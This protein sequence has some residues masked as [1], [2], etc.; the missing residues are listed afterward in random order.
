M[1]AR[2]VKSEMPNK[3]LPEP[4]STW[5]PEDI[6]GWRREQFSVLGF[7]GELLSFLAESRID[8]HSVTGW[9]VKGADPLTAVRL[10]AGLDY[11][12]ED[13]RFDHTKFDKLVLDANP[14]EVPDLPEEWFEADDEPPRRTV[15]G[16]L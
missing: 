1:P 6:A 12:G 8:A 13:E 11:A 3:S 10:E 15:S 16:I 2:P 5:N 9:V 7:K 14:V 4:N